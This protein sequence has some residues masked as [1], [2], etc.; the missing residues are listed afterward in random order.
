MHLRPMYYSLNETVFTIERTEIV[1]LFLI[2]RETKTV[3]SAH[4]V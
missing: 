2:I 1:P 3:N 4:T